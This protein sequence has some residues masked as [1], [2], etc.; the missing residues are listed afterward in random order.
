MTFEKK[1]CFVIMPFGQMGT[2]EHY[3]YLGIYQLMI[4]PVVEA[5]GY[6]AI[7]ADELEHLGNI[8]R[9]IIEL[10]HDSDLVVADLSGRNANV[11]YELGVRHA[12]Y[13]AGTIPVIQKGE[14]LPFD[15]ANYRALFYSSELGGP[16]LFKNELERRIKAFES[17]QG[18]KSDNPV[19]D[20]LGDKLGAPP[21][22]KNYVSSRKYQKIVNDNQQLQEQIKK[23]DGELKEKDTDLEKRQ[24]ENRDLQ[25]KLEKAEKEKPVIPSRSNLKFRFAVIAF[26]ILFA[27]VLTYV[28]LTDKAG[29]ERRNKELEV[30]IDTLEKLNEELKIKTK[31]DGQKVTPRQPSQPVSSQTHKQG[32]KITNNLNMGFVYIEP[33]TFKMGSPESEPQRES[34]ETLHEVEL[35]KC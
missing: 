5:C 29:L 4:K 1:R 23:K 12:L 32:D 22:L 2:P 27:S 15:I 25:L 18:D 34:D 20:I 14:I 7:R 26:F 16:D 6:K 31:I 17:G 30:K 19:H 28:Y 9:D 8:T 11:F 3:R 21:D 33:G 10:L 24:Q 35:T 13:R